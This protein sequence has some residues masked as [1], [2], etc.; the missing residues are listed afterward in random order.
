MNIEQITQ[1][2][3][4]ELMQEM[5]LSSAAGS[6]A[7]PYRRVLI[8]FNRSDLPLEPLVSKLALWKGKADLQLRAPRWA[9]SL[10]RGAGFESSG[11]QLEFMSFDRGTEAKDLVNGCD[12]V[13]L[14]GATRTILHKI[15][16][17]DRD[18]LTS[19]VVV[20][21]LQ[22]NKPV[23]LLDDSFTSYG[24]E[25]RKVQDMGVHLADLNEIERIFPLPPL[26]VMPSAAGR[27]TQNPGQTS[28]QMPAS[29][30]GCQVVGQCA[31]VC[32]DRIQ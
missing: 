10:W 5:Y 12:R 24:S 13:A 32:N 11:L 20:E 21:A 23:I 18:H 2:V 16:R 31:T 15:G 29:C 1:E 8:L 22:R 30:Q 14:I 3:V 4:K 17:M 19:A 26:P 6:P 7:V 28:G 25:S 27:P 9:Q